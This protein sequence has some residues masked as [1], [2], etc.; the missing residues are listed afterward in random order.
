MGSTT[1]TSKEEVLLEV[2]SDSGLTLKEHLTSI[3]SKANKKLH[4]LTTVSEFM[5]LKIHELHF[6]V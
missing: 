2:R 5:S 3:C 4:A 6:T 1:K